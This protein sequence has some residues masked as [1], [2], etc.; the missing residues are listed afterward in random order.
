MLFSRMCVR[1]WG[2]IGF[3]ND[4]AFRYGSVGIRLADGSVFHASAIAVQDR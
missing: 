3:G 4:V 1:K 2:E